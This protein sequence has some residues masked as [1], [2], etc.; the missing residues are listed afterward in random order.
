MVIT[1]AGFAVLEPERDLVLSRWV[2]RDRSLDA[3]DSRIR[4]VF[5]S[6]IPKGGYVLDCGAFLGSHTVVYAETVGFEGFVGAFEPTPRHIECL[7]YNTRLFPQVKVIPIAL[8]SEETSL[9]LYPNPF[10]AGATVVGNPDD[11]DAIEVKAT[12]IDAFSWDRL[13]FIKIDVEGLVLR[14]LEGAK[15]T[16]LQHLPLVVCEVG[17]NLELFGDTTEDVISFMERLGY[18]SC[19]LPSMNGEDTTHQRDLLFKPIERS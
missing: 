6:M 5:A 2:E 7:R 1:D 12:T 11:F 13:D 3:Y 15:Q 10:N 19:E 8:Y 18:K 14:V 4:Q 16:L 17:D 9:W